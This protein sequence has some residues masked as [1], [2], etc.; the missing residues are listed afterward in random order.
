MWNFFSDNAI[1]LS[2]GFISLLALLTAVYHGFATR[3]HFRLSV[4]PNL[5]IEYGADAND[6]SIHITIAN[7]GLGPAIIKNFAIVMEE[8]TI[9]PKD[10]AD[11]ENILE[12]IYNTSIYPTVVS[13]PYLNEALSP[14]KS[15]TLIRI[16]MGPDRVITVGITDLM[17]KFM[18]FKIKIEYQSMYKE[19]FSAEYP[20]KFG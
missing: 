20:P 3:K 6:K 5:S 9:H 14:K 4:K 1:A 2:A 10:P 15:I 11:V 17:K 8:K 12:E 7:E 19:K 18:P 16:N 13:I